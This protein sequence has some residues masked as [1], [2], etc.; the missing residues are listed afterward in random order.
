MRKCHMQEM[1]HALWSGVSF[2][3]KRV[4][5]PFSMRAA[6]S[7]PL[8]WTACPCSM[9]STPLGLCCWLGVDFMDESHAMQVRYVVDRRLIFGLVVAVEQIDGCAREPSP[10]KHI[11]SVS[12]YH[13]Q[14]HA[15]L[16]MNGKLEFQTLSE[17]RSSLAMADVPPWRPSQRRR[18]QSDDRLPDSYY[19]QWSQLC[20]LPLPHPASP[21]SLAP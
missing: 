20:G 8:K 7:S 19:L 2:S 13:M 21:R 1:R 16:S 15:S 17:S 12:G 3:P 18:N 9:W 5:A 11:T 14:D 6:D 4:Q 10:D